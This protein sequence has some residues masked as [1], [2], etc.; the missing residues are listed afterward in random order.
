MILCWLVLTERALV[1]EK[2]LWLRR[3]PVPA[4]GGDGTSLFYRRSDYDAPFVLPLH[5]NRT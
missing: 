5:A 3:S 4:F 1:Q 2:L